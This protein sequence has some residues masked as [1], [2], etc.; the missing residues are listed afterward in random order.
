MV[1]PRAP[2]LTAVATTI[3]GVVAVGTASDAVRVSRA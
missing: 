2:M 3:A 1:L